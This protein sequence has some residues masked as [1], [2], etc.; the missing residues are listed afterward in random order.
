MTFDPSGVNEPRVIHGLRPRWTRSVSVPSEFSTWSEPPP[1][2]STGRAQLWSAGMSSFE[3]SLDHA[4][5]SPGRSLSWTRS[6]GR[7][8]GVG[9][10]AQIPSVG[11]YALQS[12]TSDKTHARLV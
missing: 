7:P 3:P 1:R 4:M 10:T 8:P 5:G 2:F 11:P 9:F 6:V 12:H